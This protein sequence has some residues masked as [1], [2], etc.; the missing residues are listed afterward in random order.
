MT[1]S[2]PGPGSKYH[3]YVTLSN[4]ESIVKCIQVLNNTELDGRMIVVE[5]LRRETNHKNNATKSTTSN[6]G[7]VSGNSIHQSISIS[8]S[9]GIKRKVE[10]A[11]D[12]EKDNLVKENLKE[13]NS[14]KILS[15]NESIKDSV[16]KKDEKVNT[17]ATSSTD[18]LKSNSS[19]R[20]KD[21]GYSGSRNESRSYFDNNKRPAVR[22]TN[23]IKRTSS[24]QVSRVKPDSHHS[25]NSVSVAKRRY[26]SSSYRDERES[27]IRRS[28]PT[29]A[30]HD[31]FRKTASS[32]SVSLSRIQE[33][34]ARERSK[35]L[36]RDEDRD[37]QIEKSRIKSIEKK[38]RDEI[39][40]L[41]KERERLR[42]EREKLE[43]EKIENEKLK[44][45]NERL[46]QERIK[47]ELK[48]QKEEELRK[49]RNL[50]MRSANVLQMQSPLLAS[51]L[52][53]T[54]LPTNNQTIPNNYNTQPIHQNED[55]YQASRPYIENASSNS[56][57]NRYATSNDRRIEQKSPAAYTNNSGSNGRSSGSN[58]INPSGNK[59]NTSHHASLPTSSSSSS[60]FGRKVE[61]YDR[62]Q[63][64]DHNNQIEANNPGRSGNYDKNMNINTQNTSNNNNNN[65]RRINSDSRSRHSNSSNNNNNNS[66]SSNSRNNNNNYDNRQNNS[67]NANISSTTSNNNNN[68]ST[69]TE[70]RIEQRDR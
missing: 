44:L 26:E 64:N 56:N 62:Q 8:S 1:K 18:G 69:P 58:T 10:I 9:S 21:S 20:P 46:E 40:K 61:R 16:E 27:K 22:V 54:R 13:L 2:R 60:S 17:A 30:S 36:Q 68:R 47:Q 28:S 48:L 66:S 38:Q 25:S 24:S 37:R 43:R 14:E 39:D 53:N 3:G 6:S 29:S 45:Y 23:D 42:I 59:N 12:N 51:P 31:K 50:E 41:A 55:Y 15:I 49:K 5:K 4:S 67:N 70:N 63:S 19:Q 35:R 57:T 11:K 7:V 65:N 34:R 52:T 32:S 33:E